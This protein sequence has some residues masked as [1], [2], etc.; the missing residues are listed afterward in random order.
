MILYQ[1]Y[2][3]ENGLVIKFN[4]Y[5]E[6]EIV[7]LE[8]AGDGKEKKRNTFEVL[9]KEMIENLQKRRLEN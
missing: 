9:L 5:N 1:I 2:L 4:K 3:D 6:K 8:I 7:N